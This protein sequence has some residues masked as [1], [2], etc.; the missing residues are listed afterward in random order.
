MNPRRRIWAG[1]TVL[2]AAAG[3]AGYAK[4]ATAAGEGDNPS[5]VFDPTVVER[6][7]QLQADHRKTREQALKDAKAWDEGRPQR[8]ALDRAALAKIWSNLV[9]NADAQA[10]LRVHAERMA[11]LNRMLDLT[12]ASAEVAVTQRIQTAIQTELLQHAQNMQTLRAAL[13]P[14]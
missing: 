5:L 8:A 3:P 4:Q 6:L 9:D 7:Q 11:R 13:R 12:Q 2:C 14:E 1:I 10:R